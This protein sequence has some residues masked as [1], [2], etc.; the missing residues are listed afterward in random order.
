MELFA[1]DRPEDVFVSAAVGRH[2][3]TQ[4][5]YLGVA[6]THNTVKTNAQGQPNRR[7]QGQ[8]E[9]DALPLSTILE[10]N[11]AEWDRID[12]LSVDVEGAELDVLE[13]ADLGHWQPTLTII[14]L[15]S[16]SIDRVLSHP[17]HELM[18][19]LGYELAAWTVLDVFYLL[20]SR[21]L[22]L[23]PQPQGGAKS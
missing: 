21:R 2:A 16:R 15:T 17:I 6:P 11:A 10:E 14:E 22:L 23:A 9:V 13:S 5:L 20:P 1:R 8:I 4:T 19:G 18:T 7:V 3:G 12:L